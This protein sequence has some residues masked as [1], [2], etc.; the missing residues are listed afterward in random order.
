MRL[1]PPVAGLVVFEAVGVAEGSAIFRMEARS[2]KHANPMGTVHG[3]ILCDC[4]SL[5]DQGESFTT[6]ELRINLLPVMDGL[7]EVR[8]RAVHNERA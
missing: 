1:P 6:L 2:E 3:G 7:L 4:A 5:L 8:A